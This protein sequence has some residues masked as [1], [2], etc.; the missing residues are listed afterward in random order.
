[1][2]DSTEVKKIETPKVVPMEPEVSWWDRH[3]HNKK[4]QA[5]T[6][7]KQRIKRDA[8]RN[9]GKDLGDTRKYD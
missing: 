5:E 1:M 9:A 7:R 2:D 4:K 3:L 8:V 6:F